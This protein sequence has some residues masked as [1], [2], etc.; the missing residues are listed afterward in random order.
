MC[1]LCPRVGSSCISSRPGYATQQRIYKRFLHSQI[2]CTSGHE[3][4]LIKIGLLGGSAK[5]N[6]ELA[7]L[8]RI[9]QLPDI[10]Y[11]VP[12]RYTVSSTV[13]V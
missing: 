5:K 2:I 10:Q 4:G 8:I 3:V 13:Y 1:Y 11:V 9:L 6:N 12:I 7:E